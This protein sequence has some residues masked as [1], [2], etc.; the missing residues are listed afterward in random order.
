MSINLFIPAAG[1][2]TRL[3]PLTEATPKP[4][5]PICGVPLMQRIIEQISEKLDI[6]Q[7]GVNTHYLPEVVNEWSESVTFKE[8]IQL[9][10]EDEILGTGGALK[11]AAPLLSKKPFILA[12]GDVLMD[13]DW[14]G[15]LDHHRKSG[16]L[17][18]LAVQDRKH[19]KR[20]GASKDNKLVCIDKSCSDPRV[21]HWYGYACAAIY[22]PE[23]LDHLPE[24]ESHVVPFW[25][26]AAEKTGRVGVYDIGAENYWL[27]LGT[28]ES[29]VQASID[30]LNG[31]NRFFREPL[32]IPM[33]CELHNTV[34]IESNTDIGAQ[35][36]LSN[37]IILPNSK[38]PEGSNLKNC[39][40][41][42]GFIKEIE[43]PALSSHK[44]S[45]NKIGNGGSDR[46]Y[47]RENGRVVL[48]YSAFEE[49]VPRQIELTQAFRDNG[50][51]VPDIYDH[52]PLLRTV[53]LEDLGDTTFRQWRESASIA[54][55]QEQIAK[56]L[57]ELE[58]FQF[59]NPELCPVIKDK[60]FNEDVLLWETSY[61]LE[62]FVQ[63]VCGVCEDF[64]EL[65]L[66]FQKLAK[67]VNFLPKAIMHRDFQ[68]ENIMIKENQP[69]FIDFQGA[70]W[71]TPFYD[72]G[73]FLKDPYTDFTETFR[74]S[75]EEDYLERLGTRFSMSVEECHQAYIYCSMQ[76]H[77]QALGAYG[78]L[79]LIRGKE[80]F[81]R[82]AKP[83]LAFLEVEVAEYKDDFP[84]LYK[85][86]LKIKDSV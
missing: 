48:H 81:L 31:A 41:G 26:D 78:F 84:T 32:K 42:P 5:L 17:I 6:D 43:W 30:T 51:K 12:N 2:G 77:M 40:V 76:R 74:K 22:E 71:G 50:V 4:L 72:L 44:E 49:N 21:D 55:E 82:H 73:S 23:F 60:H 8:K 52:K 47:T 33:D 29:F 57:N 54:Q 25:V 62:R 10:H 80:D 39:I 86:V 53:T 58:K 27:D 79:S 67:A 37:V 24:G 64:S 16:N 11:N 36:E 14:Q 46:L 20:V 69:W 45:L 13:L 83:A 66:E 68:S 38:I 34:I 28:P 7:I 70:H 61:F 19:E 35:A 59:I 63:R 9:F 56:I 85:L 1:L 15:L 18:T 75:F 3:R 65:K